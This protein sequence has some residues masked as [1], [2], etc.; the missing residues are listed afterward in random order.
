[1]RW[2]FEA[3]AIS[4]L[5][6]G[7][8]HAMQRS[9]IL[10]L[11]ENARQLFFHGFDNYMEHA[12]PEDELRP[13]SCKGQG[14]DKLN[15][16]NVGRNDV[17]GDFALTLIDTLDAFPILGDQDTFEKAVRDVIDTVTF[18]VDSKVQIFEVTIRVLGGLLSAHQFA[19]STKMNSTIAW[20]DNEL[21]TLAVDLGDR[22]LPAFDSPT[23]IPYP[24]INLRYGLGGLALA[25][26][27]ETCAA[28]A[29]T[30]VLE[31]AALSRLTGD[32]IYEK[33]AIRS[34]TAIW[35]RRLELGLVGNTIDVKTGIWTTSS[36]SVG[37]GVDSFYEYALKAWIFTG[38]D[39]FY[40]V[41]NQ[42][43]AAISAHVADDENF[44]LRNVHVRT[45]FLV[46]YV[47]F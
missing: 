39:Y 23:G 44:L 42:S 21:L 15:A 6:F 27:T 34:F 1:M 2:P 36:T 46:R 32:P 22:L 24:R 20:Y 41:W 40:D 43:H 28:G 12:F 17:C 47:K 5:V 14:S 11:R 35:E 10:A 7:I 18:D 37:A 13:L 19:T 3:L 26:T 31:F 25:E 8:V 16:G 29:G 30:L 33:V 9:Q 38:N 45:G 4:L